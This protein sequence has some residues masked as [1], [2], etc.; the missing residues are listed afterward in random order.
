MDR[1][2][3]DIADRLRKHADDKSA[4]EDAP[5][6]FEE[7]YRLRA[8]ILGVLIRD[9]RQAADLSPDDCAS[10]IGVPV[11]LLQAWEFGQKMPNLPQLELLAYVLNVPI[12]HFWGTETL[13]HEAAR[14]AVDTGE[15][16][17]L[18]NRLIGGLL[19]AAR[20][21]ANLTPEQLAAE[22]GV[23]AEHV[24]TYELGQREIPAPVLVSLAQ[25]CRVNVSYFLEDGNRV[26]DYLALREDLKQFS[27]LP[28]DVRHFVSSPVNQ[29]Y[30]E[31][32]MRLA[33]MSSG[34]LRG[35]A[36]AILDITL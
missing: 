13:H 2:F 34:E 9:A 19:R 16:V 30:I 35:I 8:R 24:N 20:T 11:E 1:S 4:Q 31:L 27:E 28:D 5:R 10:Q 21:Q 17:A 32:A 7:L 15:Y 14:Q 6:N 25:A 12:S 18:R 26:G 23:S 22:A 36:E 3:G 33:R 29:A